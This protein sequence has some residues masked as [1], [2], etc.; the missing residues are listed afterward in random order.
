MIV[1]TPRISLPEEEVQIEYI[2]S[3]GPGGQNVNKVATAVQLR[4]DVR[5]SR[6]LPEDVRRRL[7][8]LAG[9]RVNAEGILVLNARRFRTQERNKTDVLAR[10]RDLVARASAAPA[11]RRPTR[12]TK[13]SKERRLKKKRIK[14]V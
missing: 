7:I 13:G 4:Y 11:R 9:R 5:R 2:R 6:S 8:K 14:E 12:P 1:L 3:S 10:L